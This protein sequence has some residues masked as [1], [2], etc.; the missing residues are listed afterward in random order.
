MITKEDI[1]EL[2]LYILDNYNSPYSNCYDVCED[3]RDFLSDR[4]IPSTVVRKEFGEARV[5]H[6]VLSINNKY[7]SDIDGNGDTYIDPTITQFNSY[8]Y[9]NG[10]VKVDLGPEDF[11]V[12]QQD[13]RTFRCGRNASCY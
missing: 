11:I 12:P 1:R 2:S 13:T 9:N 3:L 6:Y 8:N 7:I 10:K 4:D 5:T